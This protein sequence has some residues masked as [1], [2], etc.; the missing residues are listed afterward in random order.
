MRFT[1]FIIP[2]L[3]SL[4][5]VACGHKPV[6][7][8]T[9]ANMPHAKSLQDVNIALV[10]GGG[11]ARGVAHAGVLSVL[12]ENQ[13][14]IDLVVGTSIGSVMG[15]LYCSDKDAKSLTQLV[16]HIKKWDVLDINVYSHVRMAWGLGGLV[17]GNGLKTFLLKNL[18]TKNFD[19]LKI[20]LAVV[21]TDIEE[22]KPFVIR[23]GPII[24]AVHASSAIPLVFVP[25]SLYG[26]LLV[27]GGVMSP[28]PVEIA[29]QL[30][31]KKV[32][33]VDIGA[34]VKKAKVNSS[35]QLADRT[36]WLSYIALSDWETKES[37]VLIQPEFNS[38][39]TFDD[40]QLMTYYLS[41]RK[42]AIEALPQIKA[43][44]KE[45]Q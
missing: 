14:P 3:L 29:K 37:D 36:L 20:P 42:A 23:S 26:H 24:P 43:L 5:L 39:S 18:N 6:Y 15:A 38:T 1:S 45:I 44:I 22:A 4:T 31:A 27:D 30:G 2:L 10:L 25:V 12:E 33:A 19:Q 9:P 16:T 32:I 35:Y 40:S 13:I 28:V 7:I 21:T 8:P 11:G 17:E 41:G 34:V